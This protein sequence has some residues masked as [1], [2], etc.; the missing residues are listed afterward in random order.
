MSKW[1]VD[2]KSIYDENGQLIIEA[3]EWY[4][5][6]DLQKLCNEHN[7][8][9]VFKGM[10]NPYEEIIPIIQSDKEE[11]SKWINRS[12]FHFKKINEL[13]NTLKWIKEQYEMDFTDEELLELEPRDE[14][15]YNTV[16]EKI[17]GDKKGC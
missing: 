15:I 9:E 5:R 8:N 2:E 7:A 13:N 12:N 1:N 11:L 14:A 16:K 3:S 6:E 10:I 4:M 17:L